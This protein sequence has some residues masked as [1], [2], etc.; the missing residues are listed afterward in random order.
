[1]TRL[2]VRL[3]AIKYKE[4]FFCSLFFYSLKISLKAT[5]VLTRFFILH[6]VK[7]SDFWQIH[8][9]KPW[10]YVHSIINTLTSC[11]SNWVYKTPKN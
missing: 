11:H 2:V 4:N 5:C 9:P 1:M 6:A 7:T 10:I 3:K 8:S